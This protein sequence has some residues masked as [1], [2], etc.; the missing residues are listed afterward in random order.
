MR[1][2]AHASDSIYRITAQ[3][4]VNRKGQRGVSVA[5]NLAAA[6]DILKGTDAV[7]AMLVDAIDGATIAIQTD[8]EYVA[9]LERA[10][11]YLEA[12]AL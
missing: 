11:S 10:R 3:P 8:P 7:I 1:S 6:E 9:T 12:G 4:Y 2:R 5:V